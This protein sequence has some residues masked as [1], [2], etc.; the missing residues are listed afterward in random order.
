MT[1]TSEVTRLFVFRNMISNYNLSHL[2]IDENNL[3]H[4]HQ[5]VFLESVS[6]THDTGIDSSCI[7]KYPFSRAVRLNAYRLI[8]LQ[9]L[10]LTLL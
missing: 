9:D 4:I 7:S 5:V 10:T 2:V 1:N 6:K 8:A 3:T